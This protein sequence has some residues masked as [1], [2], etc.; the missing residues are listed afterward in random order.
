MSAHTPG[1][2]AIDQSGDIYDPASGLGIGEAWRAFDNWEDNGRLMAAAPE[3]LEAVAF[4]HAS[5]ASLGESIKSAQGRCIV[6]AVQ[7]AL[8]SAMN[9]ARGVA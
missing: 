7:N 4:A 9:K 8:L 3:L 5:V 2:W 6:D 1:P